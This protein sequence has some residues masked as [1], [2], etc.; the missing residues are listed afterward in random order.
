MKII[1]NLV[2]LLTLIVNYS[3]SRNVLGWSTTTDRSTIDECLKVAL[4][5]IHADKHDTDQYKPKVKNIVCKTKISNGIHIKLYFD[6]EKQKWECLFYKSFVE[7]LSVQYEKCSQIEKENSP[8]KPQVNNIKEDDDDDEAK[9]DEINQRAREKDT[10]NNQVKSEDEEV[11]DNGDTK[12]HKNNQQDADNA[13]EPD[14]NEANVN[15]NNQQGSE[16]D[17]ENDEEASLNEKAEHR[18]VEAPNQQD[19]EED[20]NNEQAPEDDNNDQQQ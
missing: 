16:P 17:A 15:S 10:D 11:Q 13:E 9:I 18:N 1:W 4:S 6:L 5:H 7:T 12:I 14:D 8:E 20:A 2:F 19:Q 3:Y